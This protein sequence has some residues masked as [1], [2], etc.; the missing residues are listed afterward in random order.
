MKDPKKRLSARQ[1]L[2]HPWVQGKA[3]KTNPMEEAQ[4]N[5]KEYQARKKL[6]VNLQIFN[7]EQLPSEE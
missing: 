2:Q 6:K 1:A 4:K 7:F 5:L 3:V